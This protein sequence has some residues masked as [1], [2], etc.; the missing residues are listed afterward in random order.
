MSLNF[1]EMI[2]AFERRFFSHAK[3]PIVSTGS[4]S[5]IA[6]AYGGGLIPSVLLHLMSKLAQKYHFHCDSYS[7]RTESSC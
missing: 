4:Q 6:I 5:T 1:F 2:A 7:S 3:E